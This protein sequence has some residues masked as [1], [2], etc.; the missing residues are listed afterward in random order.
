MKNAVLWNVTPKCL[1][2]QQHAAS[3]SRRRHSS[4][5]NSVRTA[6]E[7]HQ[8]SATKANRLMLFRERVSV[9]CE[10]RT[11][12]AATL[13]TMWYI[14]L[15]LGVCYGQVPL[16]GKERCPVMCAVRVC[17]YSEDRDA[18]GNC[19]SRSHTI[20]VCDYCLVQQSDYGVGACQIAERNVNFAPIFSKGCALWRKIM[21]IIAVS[22]SHTHSTILHPH[23]LS[24]PPS[25]ALPQYIQC[26]HQ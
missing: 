22:E 19:Y 11:E 14:Q 8:T 17:Q 16:K 12:H 25:L 26:V 6:E 7:T 21:V 20:A 2:L 23:L 10:I 15:P 5:L 4:C 1:F 13:H 24:S 18:S 3:H 9:Y